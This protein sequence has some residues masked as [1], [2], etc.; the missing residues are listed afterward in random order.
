ME[1]IDLHLLNQPVDISVD[2]KNQQN[3]LFI[4]K[5][6][7]NFDGENGDLVMKRSALKPRMAFNQITSPIEGDES[8][9]FP[10]VYSKDLHNDFSIKFVSDNIIRLS[11]RADRTRP[12]ADSA[13]LMLQ[14]PLEYSGNWSM[15]REGDI[16]QYKNAQGTVKL[17][18]GDFAIEV[19]DKHDKRLFRTQNPNDTRSLINSDPLPFCIVRKSNDLRREIAFSYAINP[20][21]KFYGCG[22]SFTR[23]NK[24]GQKVTLYTTDASGVQTDKMY[25]P[26]PFFIC[27]S[28]YGMFAHTS[29]PVTYDFGHDYDGAA[30]IYTADDQLDLFIILGNPAQVIESYTGIT[31]RSKMPPLWSFGLWMSR[32]TYSSED[33]VR[34]VAGKL[35]ENRIPCDVIHI[36]TGWFEEH[37]QCNYKFSSTRFKDPQNMINDLSDLGFKI[38]LWQLP[39]FSPKNELYKEAVDNGYVVTDADGQLPT[40]D[41]IIDFSDAKA[42]EWYKGLLKKLIKMG[43]GAIKADFGEAAPLTGCYKS[44]KSGLYEHN[45]YPLRYNKAVS[46]ATFDVSGENIIWARSAWA[47]SQRY[48]LHW[49]GDAENTDCGMAAS[50][51]GG[52][53][54]GLSGFT[55]WSHD[56]GGFVKQSPEDLYLRWLF[57]GIFTSHSRCHGA[58]PKEP[59]YYSD[60]FL[61][62]FR[63]LVEFKY[64]LIPYIYAQS[65]ESCLHGW[66]LLRTL[67]FQYPDDPVS[68]LIE[69]E[70]L[71]GRDI[72]VA[73]LMNTGSRSRKVYLP[74]GDWYE[75]QSGNKYAGGDWHDI[76]CDG[77]PGVVMLRGGCAIPMVETSQNTGEIN[78]NKINVVAAGEGVAN[79]LFCLPDGEPA[80]FC[81]NS[82]DSINLVYKDIEFHINRLF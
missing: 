36:D 39:Y 61:D 32:I 6:I 29:T 27:S 24:R 46:E 34:E 44:G 16:Y 23:L 38:S 9:E 63:E 21:D 54:L 13:S 11:V 26:I 55:F 58:P 53:S 51:R 35:R 76:K 78:W 47:G 19:Y 67:F 49:G 3:Q 62:S 37:W 28:G 18:T 74:E 45:L 42:V 65:V 30:T 40:E 68:W 75:F 17:F 50:L 2:F 12:R 73:P 69:D 43:T 60:G 81:I 5:T 4:V 31:G 48:P 79:G 25:K 72:L 66:P 7:E 33:E 59:W 10:P 52:L 82:D 77:F 20:D 56:I 1:N 8:W 41:A 57:F 70:Y 71:F 22:E 80:E 15:S 64:K 14:A